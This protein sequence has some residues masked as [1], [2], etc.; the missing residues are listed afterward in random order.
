MISKN[1]KLLEIL[2][3]LHKRTFSGVLRMERNAEKKQ[4]VIH[5]GRLVC[6]ESNAPAEHLARI[7]VSMDLIPRARLNEIAAL[8]KKG[9]TSEEAILELSGPCMP[10]LAKARREQAIL[11]FASLWAWNDCEMHL[12]PADGLARYRLNLGLPLPELMVLSLRRAAA[13]RLISAPSEFSQERLCIAE[14]FAEN[15]LLYPLNKAESY[16][17]SL[18]Q[19]PLTVSDL[20]RMIPET[21]TKHEE[22]LFRLFLL[23]LV[24]VK[25]PDIQVDDTSPPAE[26]SCLVGEIEDILLRF[27]TAGLYE[28]LTVPPEASPEEI[29]AAYHKLAKRYHPDCFQSMEFSAELRA[30]AEKAFAIINEAYVT[31]K[32]PASRARYN[33]KRIAE[34][35]RVEAELRA[36]SGRQTEDKKVAEAL[37]RDG[38]VLLAKGD[39]EKAIE[40]LKGCVWL[41]PENA[42]YHHYLGVALAG[43]PKL[44]KSAEQ[45]LLKAIELDNTSSESRLELAK[46]YINV[47]LRR[48]AALQLEEL[49]RWDPDNQK[50]HRLLDE[51]KKLPN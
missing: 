28:V 27:Q 23:G 51:L 33:E 43:I 45:H 31:L 9:K 36:R 46:L 50:A 2:L 48:K 24:R 10:D 49:M 18:L 5:N 37:Y 14:D 25:V 42:A 35:G 8:M 16:V 11:I 17:Y 12:Y 34:G 22:L 40:R 38:R 4:M 32:D 15:A 3:D 13:D 19:T 20:A 44:R 26:I 47:M 30:K 29:Q 1:R 6:A 7:M 41:M 39:F 21:E